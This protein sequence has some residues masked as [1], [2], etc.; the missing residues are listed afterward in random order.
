MDGGG[1]ELLERS[2]YWPMCG[3]MEEWWSDVGMVRGSSH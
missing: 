1:G 2:A 3:G